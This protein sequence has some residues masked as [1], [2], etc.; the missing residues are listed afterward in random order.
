M[1]QVDES[2]LEADGTQQRDQTLERPCILSPFAPMATAHTDASG[3]GCFSD[4]PPKPPLATRHNASHGTAQIHQPQAVT[5]TA[6]L[7]YGTLEVPLKLTE[8][9]MIVTCP[10][11][12]PTPPYLWSP[13]DMSNGS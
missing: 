5:L 10:I 8:D 9:N 7:D 4:S 1:R 3:S 6:L 13:V 2:N 12:H 11:H